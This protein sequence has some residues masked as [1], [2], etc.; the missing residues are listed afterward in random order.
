MKIDSY[1][2][3][4]YPKLAAWIEEEFPKVVN[5]PKIWNAFVKYSELGATRAVWAVTPGYQPE[6]GWKVMPGKNGSYSFERNP[7][8][9]FLAKRLCDEFEQAKVLTAK[10]IEKVESTLLH[11]FVHWGDEKDGIDQKGE[12][13]RK[14]EVEAYGRDI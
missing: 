5:K 6:V 2:R 3:K 8:R 4:E 11:E 1:F 14:F 7:Y 10:L 13:G 9:V 12:E